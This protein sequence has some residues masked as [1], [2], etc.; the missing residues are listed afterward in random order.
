MQ[1]YA[2]L[3][4]AVQVMDSD[5]EDGGRAAKGEGPGLSRG[6]FNTEVGQ[7]GAGVEECVCWVHWV[8]GKGEC[9]GPRASSTPERRGLFGRWL[10]PSRASRRAL[11]SHVL[12]G[13]PSG[14]LLAPVS[15]GSLPLCL[16]SAC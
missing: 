14:T 10:R 5:E 8:H 3:C 7:P 6:D 1:C 12:E 4:C 16:T 2:A 11:A 9:V 13:R 15:C